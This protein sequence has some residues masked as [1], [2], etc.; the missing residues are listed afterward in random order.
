MTYRVFICRQQNWVKGGKTL[1]VDF[2]VAAQSMEQNRWKLRRRN[3]SYTYWLKN[4]FRK[5]SVSFWRA[6]LKWIRPKLAFQVRSHWPLN[7]HPGSIII[8]QR[9]RT[10][11]GFHGAQP[12]WVFPLQQR[13]KPVPVRHQGT[14]VPIL[15]AQQLLQTWPRQ[16]ECPAAGWHTTR[17]QR[18][19]EPLCNGSPS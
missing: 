10:L 6:F 16:P 15:C 8:G 3:F 19:P 11:T 17:H 13:L 12:V 14:H 4:N 5:L 18:H 1:G 2:G 7:I 9:R